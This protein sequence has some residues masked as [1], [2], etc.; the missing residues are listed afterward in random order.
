M[1]ERPILFSGPMVRAILDGSKT[2]TRRVVTDHTSQG[3]YKASEMLLD[4]PS[5]W[6]DPGPSPAGNPGPYLK[7]HL[8]APLVESNHGW[9][10]GDCCPEVV[11]RLYPR[12]FPGDLLWV[13]E[14]FAYMGDPADKS[15]V[16]REPWPKWVD[17]QPHCDRG[18][19]KPSIHMPKWAS[20]LWLRVTDVRVERVQDISPRDAYAEGVPARHGV[21]V[22]LQD[23]RDLWDSI[24][25][26]RAPWDSNPWVW[27][28]SFERK[29]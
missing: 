18:P 25:A 3:N 23:F 10:P 26:K 17:G 12:I 14:A 2:Q 7:A 13:R 28:V 6:V 22:I 24:N 15:I 16:W 5:T 21:S 8:N 27:V 4:D 20:R 29:L 11:E 1:D 19:W 9:D